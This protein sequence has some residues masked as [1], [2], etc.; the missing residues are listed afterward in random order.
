MTAKLIHSSADVQSR[1][2][3]GNTR[4]WQYVVILEHAVIGKDCNICS[5]CF[6]ENDV[7]IGDRVTVK[8]GVQLWDGLRIEDDVFIGSNATFTNDKFPRSKQYPESFLETFVRKGASIGANATI[9]PGVNIGA[10]A[11]IG[12]GAVVTMNVP[13]MAIVAGNPARI[14]GYVDTEKIQVGA[15]D[16]K[17]QLEQSRVKGVR[18]Y[19]LQHVKD[20]RG[21]L[22]AIEWEKEMPF[23]PK[24]VFFVYNVPSDR[25]RG[26][27]AHK[28]CHEYLVCTKGSV[29]VIVD[30]GLNREEYLLNDP[31]LGLYFPPRTWTIQYK[32]SADA[33]LFV[34]ASHEY[35]ASDYIRDY[36]E[37]LTFLKS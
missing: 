35:D 1:S 5:H 23:V 6:I 31:S 7:Q 3:G 18:L 25:V 9:L 24:R 33:I 12:T 15:A 13:T 36:E 21:G 22:S 26:E 32:Y 10:G 4:I 34:L 19:R 17:E 8:S 11:M 30:D 28:Q 16:T 20:L 14:V 29:S 2:I 27:H 37:Y